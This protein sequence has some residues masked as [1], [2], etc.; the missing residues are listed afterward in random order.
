M[1]DIYTPYG[2]SSR[3]AHSGTFGNNQIS[4][5]STSVSS[6]AEGSFW[7]E[8]EARLYESW[9]SSFEEYSNTPNPYFDYFFSGQDI[10]IKIDVLGDNDF[11]PI[12]SF[13]YRIQ[14]EKIPI[15]GFSSYTYDAIL[16][17][18][19]IISGA[20]SLVV[21][22]PQLL[23]SKIAESA[24]IRAQ[25]SQ[26]DSANQYALHHLDGDMA[27]IERYW[28]RNYD[29]NLYGDKNLFS[30]HPPFNFLIKYG[31]QDTT[32]VG[33]NPNIRVNEI[34]ND[35]NQN[36]AMYSNTNERLVQSDNLTKTPSKI[37][38]ENIELINKSVEYDS[39]GDPILETYSFMAR[40]ERIVTNPYTMDRT[41][42]LGSSIGTTESGR[43]SGGGGG[44]NL[45]AV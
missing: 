14:Q 3:S 8:E 33:K 21:T 29:S 1:L 10:K 6:Y 22:E 20:F 41:R 24:R 30:I 38:L 39:S 28:Q 2:S 35:F 25:T 40:D 44:G 26:A 5:Y 34:K 9:A 23:T 19:R 45:Q 18:T 36:N 32:L 43:I 12:Y 42:T 13:G 7:T 11:L 15:Y 31:L 17:G 27:D 4:S 37:L 16:R